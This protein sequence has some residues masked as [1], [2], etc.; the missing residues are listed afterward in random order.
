MYENGE[1]NADLSKKAVE[2]AE[3]I[4][5]EAFSHKTTPADAERIADESIDFED[6]LEKLRNRRGLDALSDYDDYVR[7]ISDNLERILGK[8]VSA[9]EE[10]QS[11]PAGQTLTT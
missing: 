9:D 6:L 1:S 10:R 7:R 5:G 11:Y 8:Y 2:I 3:R 4:F